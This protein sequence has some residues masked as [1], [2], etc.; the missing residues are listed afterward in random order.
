MIDYD[1]LRSEYVKCLSDKSR[2]YMITHYLKTYDATRQ[3][4]VQFN[5]FPKQQELCVTL[6][7]ANNV[8][9][10]KPRQAGI[11]TVFS[12]FASCEIVLADIESPQTILVIGN[13]LDL[14]QQMVTKIRDFLLQFPA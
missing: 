13:T 8:V 3:K 7:N 9:T 1:Y 6:G 4:E 5:L 11:T 10:K 12:A 2:I 14:A